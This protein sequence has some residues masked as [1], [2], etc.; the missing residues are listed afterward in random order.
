MTAILAAM[1][2]TSTAA[3]TLASL[4]VD[5]R[6]RKSAEVK[7]I[8]AAYRSLRADLPAG[9]TD[10]I[11]LLHALADELETEVRDQAAAS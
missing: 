2:T 6:R 8:T 4:S 3:Q 7:R 1:T 5:K 10:D 11:A 9:T